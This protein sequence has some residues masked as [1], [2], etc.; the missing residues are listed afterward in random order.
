VL[1]P[2]VLELLGTVRRE[3]FVPPALRAMAFVDTQLP[4][5]DEGMAG[6]RML[7]P[8]IEARMVQALNL[9]KHEKVLEIGTGSGFMAALLAHRAMQV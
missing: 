8:R 9:H 5:T 1:D 3:D 7:E 4:L 2:A 6:P